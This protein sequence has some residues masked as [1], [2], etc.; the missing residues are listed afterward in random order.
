MDGRRTKWEGKNRRIQF[1]HAIHRRPRYTHTHPFQA[2]GEGSIWGASR[3]AR[4]PQRGSTSARHKFFRLKP[5]PQHL[6]QIFMPEYSIAS[7]R[8]SIR[9]TPNQ[10]TQNTNQ[11]I[12]FPRGAKSW[13]ARGQQKNGVTLSGQPTA[14]KEEEKKKGDPPTAV[15]VSEPLVFASSCRPFALMAVAV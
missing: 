10:T 6:L 5:G 7:Y 14:E 9:V 3:D 8:S 15:R 4:V 11:P 2:G 1:W 12:K 13:L